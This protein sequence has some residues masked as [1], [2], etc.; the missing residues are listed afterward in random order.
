MGIASSVAQWLVLG[1]EFDG[2]EGTPAIAATDFAGCLPEDVG[3]NSESDIA[4]RTLRIHR[5]TLGPDAGQSRPSLTILQAIGWC[6]ESELLCV[7]SAHR[8]RL[9]RE[10]AR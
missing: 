8:L 3:R 7:G 5:S 9:I 2:V 10:Y 4:V 6:I 1:Q